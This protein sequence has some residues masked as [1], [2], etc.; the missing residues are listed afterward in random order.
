MKNHGPS[1]A[2]KLVDGKMVID[3]NVCKTCGVCSESKCPFKAVKPHNEVVYQIYV[4]G[5]WGKKSRMGT[6]LS[7]FVSEEEIAPYLKM[8]RFDLNLTQ[9]KK[10]VLALR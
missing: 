10:N 1:K 5:T 2:A 7:K 6:P 3:E 9:I 4:G 8:T